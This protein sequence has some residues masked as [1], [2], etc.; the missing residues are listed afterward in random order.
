MENSMSFN[1][2]LTRRLLL[3][4]S[5]AGLASVGSGLIILAETGSAQAAVGFEA[6]HGVTAAVHQANFT[7]LSQKKF[8]PISISVY[9][10]PPNVHYAA[11]WVDRPGPAFAAVHGLNAHD[12]QAA[13]ESWRNKGYAPTIVAATGAANNPVYAAVFEHGV[14]GAWR[15]RHGMTGAEFDNEVKAAANAQQKLRWAAIYGAANDPRYIAVW[16]ANPGWSKWHVF[17]NVKS[18]DYQALFQAQTQIPHFRPACVSVASDH[19]MCALFTDESIGPWVARHGMTTAEYQ[20]EFD[21]QRAAGRMPICV[22]GGG[23]G[24]SVRYAAIFAAQDQPF[25]RKW[26]MEG[27]RP[28]NMAA[29]DDIVHA[30]MVK[31]AVRG[32]QL[33]IAKNGTVKLQRA[34]TWAEPDYRPIQVS[35]RFLLASNSKMFVAAAVQKLYDT[36]KLQSTSHPYQLL[37]FS[38]PKDSR[39]DTI[40]MQQLLD[41]TAGYTHDPTYDMRKIALARGLSGP[42]GKRDIAAHM[43]AR[44]LDYAP[45]AAP[46][47]NGW[48]YNNY[49]YLLA[50]LVVEQVAGQDYF[51]FLR[52]QILQPDGISE[53]DVYPTA[54]M[55][56]PP[57]LISAEDEGLGLSAL[58]PQSNAQVPA[59]FGGDGMVKETAVGSCGTAASATALAQFIHRHAA[60]GNGGRMVSAR[61]GS[62]PGASTWAQSLGNG[63][64][65]ALVMN[66]RNW[67]PGSGK[68]FDALTGAINAELAHVS[69]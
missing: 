8:R 17:G 29:L 18:S 10:D 24:N 60:W 13:F 41:H 43:Y 34:Y 40:T 1:Q 6:Y 33:T 65:W 36:G 42:A 56:R 26:T 47:P 45:G 11:V 15:A 32:A 62:T 52:S 3:Q 53:V 61:S 63:V 38:R 20:A 30:F 69:V 64:D 9:G 57:H 50:S 37:G 22:S 21:R 39:S 58:A 23:S 49:G 51:Q 28:A 54:G 46:D 67:A 2:D 66:T 59:V 25:A 55:S 14:Q 48:I 7:R 5:G 12:Y 44:N 68:A 19:D 4:A 27:Q 16:H 35:D 31:H